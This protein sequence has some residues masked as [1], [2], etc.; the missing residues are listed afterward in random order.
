MHIAVAHLDLSIVQLLDKYGADAS[1]VNDHGVSALD[2]AV[3]DNDSLEEIRN[4]FKTQ[5]KYRR[6]DLSVRAE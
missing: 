6:F 4:Y 5:S 3:Q 2:L 1:L